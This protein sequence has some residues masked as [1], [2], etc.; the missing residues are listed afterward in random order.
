MVAKRTRDGGW[1]LLELMAIVLVL[2]ILVAIA[3]GSYKLS[4]D[5]AKRVACVSNVRTLNTAVQVY[6]QKQGGLPPDIASLQPYV[7]TK[8]ST[9]CPED[10]T[11]Y[12][13]D[14]LVG[15]VN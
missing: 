11:A 13:Y 3:V 1:T 6:E 7:T 4:S 5:S 9:A 12:T 14:D 10:G 15:R 2:G 8:V